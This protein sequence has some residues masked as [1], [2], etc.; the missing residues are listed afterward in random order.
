[1]GPIHSIPNINSK[2]LRGLVNIHGRLQICVSIGRVLGIEKL[3]KTAA[4]LD[5]DH[6]SPERLVVVRQENKLV[7]FP[8]SEVKGIVRYTSEMIKD[9][10][11]TVSGSKAV[12]TT[13]ILHLEGRD[14]GLLKDKPLFKTLTKDLE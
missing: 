7:A 13:G 8:V 4:E 1:M 9:L 3:K 5:P 12:Y 10:P 11:V 2:V 14:I 6:I